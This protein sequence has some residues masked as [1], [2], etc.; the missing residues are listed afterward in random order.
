MHYDE[1]VERNELYKN[2]AGLLTLAGGCVA[3][4]ALM[5]RF[6]A[7]LIE[8]AG[9]QQMVSVPWMTVSWS[10]FIFAGA[11]GFLIGSTIVLACDKRAEFAR[12][13]A[14]RKRNR[15]L[16]N[17]DFMLRRL[18]GGLIRSDEEK[19]LRCAWSG[20]RTSELV[21]MKSVLL[22]CKN[23]FLD[24]PS[25]IDDMVRQGLLVKTNHGG[26]A[27]LL[28][29]HKIWEMLAEEYPI[30]DVVIEPAAG[31]RFAWVNSAP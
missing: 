17:I 4:V 9:I 20:T 22:R 26:E 5:G 11:G 2:C 24:I 31:L 28:V 16:D 7:F 6:I 18:A 8:S 12:D 1:F 27:A 10:S 13:Q 15:A 21:L 30:G 14:R 3:L 23:P 29:G 25:T 19:V